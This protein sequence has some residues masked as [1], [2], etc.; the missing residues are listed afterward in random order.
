MTRRLERNLRHRWLGGVCSGFA[1]FIG[2][3]IFPVRMA[4]RILFMAFTPMLWWVYLA[5]WLFMP[6]QRLYD[7]NEVAIKRVP[8]S[9]Y[10]RSVRVEVRQLDFGDVLE[11]ARGKVSERVFEKIS[12]IDSNVRA[13][14]PSLTWWRTLTQPELATIKRSAL[15]YFPQTL[16]Q[17]LN[18]PRGYA[19]TYSLANGLTPEEKLLSELRVLENALNKALESV[20]AKHKVS[21]P[22]DLKRLNERF[23]EARNPSDE[24]KETLDNLVRR[25]QGRVP[26]D[27][28]EKITSIRAAIVSVLPQLQALPGGLTHEAYNLRQTALEYLPDALGKYLNLPASFAEQYRLSNGKTAKETLLEQLSL[29]EETVKKMVGDVYQDDTDALLIHGRF[30]KDKFATQ[31][32]ALPAGGEELR[33][34]LPDLTATETVKVKR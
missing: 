30:L 31:R 34:K 9:V 11:M 15:E 21:V 4:F 28:L 32:F 3:D 2:L 18:L 8:K 16:Q 20:Y 29:L 12:H 22:E 1:R 23:S 7:D 27:V 26:D 13:L 24:V 17:Y 33:V 14:L 19:E 25:S 5:L 6:A 10:R